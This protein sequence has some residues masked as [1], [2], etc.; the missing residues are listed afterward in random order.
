MRNNNEEN[1][2]QKNAQEILRA[3]RIY[4]QEEDHYTGRAYDEEGVERALNHG[5]RL[6]DLFG[7][8][9]IY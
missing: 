2:R 6:E 7:Y 8:N 5:R 9:G 4:R 1:N 3:E